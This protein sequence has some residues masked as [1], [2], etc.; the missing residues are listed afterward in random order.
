MINGLYK[1]YKSGGDM[2]AASFLVT[3]V[4]VELDVV[5]S[6]AVAEDAAGVESEIS[7]AAEVVGSHIFVHHE[8]LHL[9]A[10]AWTDSGRESFVP[11]DR[12]LLFAGYNLS[13]ELGGVSDTVV[14]FDLDVVLHL[15]ESV[16]TFLEGSVAD[17]DFDS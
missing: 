4:S 1:S 9:C 10:G 3:L 6:L 16:L 13:F 15:A 17:C 7:L 14:A 11:G 5:V 2:Q 12:L 8:E